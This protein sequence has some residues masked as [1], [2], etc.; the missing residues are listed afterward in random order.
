M[1][2]AGTSFLTQSASS[3]SSDDDDHHDGMQVRKKNAGGHKTGYNKSWLSRYPDIYCA[4][5]VDGEVLFCKLCQKWNTHGANGSAIWNE[6]PCRYL[7]EDK[8]KEHLTK[9]Q[10]QEAL[11]LE[12]AKQKE[13]DTAMKTSEEKGVNGAIELQKV[14][15][16]LV[17]HNLPHTTL[18]ESLVE[19]VLAVDQDLLASVHKGGNAKYTSPQ[20]VG[21]LLTTMSDVV[22]EETIK[23]LQ[24]SPTFGLM[25]DEGSSAKS[26]RKMVGASVRYLGPDAKPKVAYLAT[27]EVQDGKAETIVQ[28]VRDHCSSHNISLKKMSGLGSDGA[29]VMTGKD[30]GVGA[31]L[32]QDSSTLVAVHCN[33]HRLALAA[34]DSFKNI[35]EMRKI[36][37]L[38]DNIYNFYHWSPNWTN[39][40][41]NLQ[42]AFEKA[43][44]SIK[45][46][47]HFR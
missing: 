16:W 32:K 42:L 33:N 46:A 28:K 1:V 17:K 31:R 25:L 45:Q 26:V 13:I 23:E 44:L 41:H 24:N 15:H 6:E 27:I 3:S 20:V 35:P 5:E 29:S 22:Q 9:H 8:V 14:L 30:T 12:L 21:E 10:H 18:F 11:R 4:T 36:E 38:M 43:P 19:L 39:T 37:E 34:R 2:Q 47:K 40:L 7:R